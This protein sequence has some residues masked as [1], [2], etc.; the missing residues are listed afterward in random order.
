MHRSETAGREE[1]EEE[2]NAGG[3]I[4]VRRHD[5]QML[6]P[7][8]LKVHKLSARIEDAFGAQANWLLGVP[9]M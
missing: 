5:T 4:W 3:V 7:Q 1:E 2:E 9:S 6:S 8:K